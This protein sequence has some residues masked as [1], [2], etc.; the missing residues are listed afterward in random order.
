MMLYS[1]HSRPSISFSFVPLTLV[2][3]FPQMAWKLSLSYVHTFI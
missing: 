2:Y 1:F 3:G